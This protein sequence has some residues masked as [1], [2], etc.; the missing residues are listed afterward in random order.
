[1]TAEVRFDNRR[2][3]ELLC[4]T[5][6]KRI[7]TEQENERALA[8]LAAS[9]NRDDLAAEEEALVDLLTALV[10]DFE[11]KHCELPRTA[12]DRALRLLMQER[13][14][15]QRDLLEIFGSRGHAS[16]VV[17]G[18]RGVSKELA[19]RLGDYFRVPADLFL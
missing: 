8:V 15:Q 12:P 14:V 1:M 9:F 2:Y 11:A 19:K 5:L 17:S 7:E 10:E 3:A 6:P 4:E 13:G 16:D 18:K